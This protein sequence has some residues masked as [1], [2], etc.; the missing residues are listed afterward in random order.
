MGICMCT[1]PSTISVSYSEQEQTPD[2]SE[3]IHEHY[4]R[5][6][7]CPQLHS[8][9]NKE[10]IYISASYANTTNESSSETSNFGSSCNQS[11]L[12][13]HKKLIF[14]YTN[15]C[16]DN[17]PTLNVQSNPTST[18]ISTTKSFENLI[19]HKVSYHKTVMLKPY[20]KGITVNWTKPPH[21]INEEYSNKEKSKY[22]VPKMQSKQFERM[23][24]L[25]EI[26]E[27]IERMK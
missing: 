12:K 19:K 3:L 24:N 9:T 14:K 6:K 1:K 25:L 26:N 21:F 22:I 13:H 8:I 10:Q 23:E 15:Q 17:L 2:L 4:Q 16:L 18:R 7:E 20:V 27:Y 5:E 11:K